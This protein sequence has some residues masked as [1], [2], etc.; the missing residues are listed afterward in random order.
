MAQKQGGR[1]VLCPACK[2]STQ[3]KPVNLRNHLAKCHKDVDPNS[4]QCACG[5]INIQYLCCGNNL[6]EALKE[7]Q[8][9][10]LTTLSKRLLTKAKAK[11]FG[12]SPISEL[13]VQA[14][15]QA[16]CLEPSAT[17]QP[18]TS[19]GGIKRRTRAPSERLAGKVQK[20]NATPGANQWP[21]PAAVTAEPCKEGRACYFHPLCTFYHPEGGNDHEAA[22]QMYTE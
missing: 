22:R 13:G 1:M 8:N 14:V 9:C 7:H 2:G 17:S 10:G 11:A 21:L 3:V 15:N 18:G 20:V 19:G 5:K 16:Q 6:W 12:K 4:L